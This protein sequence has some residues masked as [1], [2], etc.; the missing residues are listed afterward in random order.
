[1]MRV[2][3]PLLPRERLRGGDVT[4]AG[5]VAPALEQAE[6]TFHQ[7]RSFLTTHGMPILAGKRKPLPCSLTGLLR[8]R[9][10]RVIAS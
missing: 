1:M 7:A 9:R 2:I 6:E 8:G 3:P 10:L 4:C 5:A